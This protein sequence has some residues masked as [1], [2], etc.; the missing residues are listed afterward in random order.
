MHF[1]YR[2]ETVS[3]NRKHCMPFKFKQLVPA[4]NSPV[5]NHWANRDRLD[6]W[7]YTII[8]QTSMQS[9]TQQQPGCFQATASQMLQGIG[10]RVQNSKQVNVFYTSL[11]SCQ[12]YRNW[13]SLNGPLPKLDQFCFNQIRQLH[14]ILLWHCD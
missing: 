14:Q 4:H 13:R 2:P 8:L 11:M 3:L 7:S 6:P 9:V 5:E 10:G 12:C 1:Y